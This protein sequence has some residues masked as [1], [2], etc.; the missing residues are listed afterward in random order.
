MITT[1]SNMSSHDVSARIIC[2]ASAEIPLTLD[3]FQKLTQRKCILRTSISEW[4]SKSEILIHLY[5]GEE[6]IY[7]LHYVNGKLLTHEP[8][9]AWDSEAELILYPQD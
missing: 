2:T 7:I 5:R 1:P 8:L 3:A 9:K 4:V 6:K